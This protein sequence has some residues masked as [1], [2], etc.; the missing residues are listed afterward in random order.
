MASAQ[1]AEA[2]AEPT[3]FG[4]PRALFVLFFAELWERFSYYGMRALLVFH[5]VGVFHE[6]QGEASVVYGAYT[7]LV[8]ALGIFGGLIADRW[9]GYKRSIMLGGAI[10]AVGC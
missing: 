10:M 8:Y 9:L 5:L 7:S 2:V 6:S 1:D 3:T 4:H